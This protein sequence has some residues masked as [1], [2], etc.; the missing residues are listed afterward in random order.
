MLFL[1]FPVIKLRV[2]QIFYGLH[3]QRS[4]LQEED[5]L[6]LVSILQHQQLCLI[7]VESHLELLTLC[8]SVI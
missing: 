6:L 4:F 5:F 7:Y 8:D 2:R 3:R 1:V